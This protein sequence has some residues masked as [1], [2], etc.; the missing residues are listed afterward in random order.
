MA[1][2]LGIAITKIRLDKYFSS[3]KI[4]RFVGQ[5][6]EVVVIPKKN[7]SNIGIE[8]PRIIRKIL[9]SHVGYLKEYYQRNL[10]EGGFAS[11]KGRFGRMIRQ[12]RQD[13]QETALFSI[14]LLQNLFFVRVRSG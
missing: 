5:I 14:G 8:W 3:R 1:E 4:L 9:K 2:G 6:V 13:C 11:D 7:I 10:G 12:K